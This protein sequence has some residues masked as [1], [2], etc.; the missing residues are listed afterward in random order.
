MD[1]I[2]NN[3]KG[4]N[5]L[6]KVTSK[7]IV[8][9]IF[10]ILKQHR[11]LDLI[12]YN[13]KYQ[14]LM[15]K[16]IVDYKK[17]FSKIEIGI[18]PKENEYGKFINLYNKSMKSNIEIYFNNSKKET[19]SETITKN[20]NVTKIK[21]IINHKLKSL[22]RLFS[23]CTCIKKINFIKF[24]KD[25]IKNMSYMFNKCSNLEEINFSNF[26]TNNVL[27]MGGMFDDCSS[28]KELNLSNFDTK[29]VLY[30]YHM[31]KG[32]SSL[33]EL[34]LSNFNNN[35]IKSTYYM[36][37]GCSSNL[38]LICTNELIK[39]AFLLKY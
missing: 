19:K 14:K 7:Y 4:N 20:D 34:N 15:N 21:I 25:D 26:N 35:S 29:N 6:I 32:C 16:N 31:F 38:S 10:G 5:V 9:K 8:I 18:I 39:G 23:G 33:K 24:N 22:F 12:H 3:L 17:E 13:K 30:M 28:L 2:N 37:K 1:E 27:N 36:F 11:L